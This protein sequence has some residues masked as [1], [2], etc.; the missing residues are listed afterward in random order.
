MRRIIMCILI[1][2]V[3]IFVSYILY[4][5]IENYL[6][7]QNIV[8]ILQCTS[9]DYDNNYNDVFYIDGN[10]NLHEVDF[11]NTSEVNEYLDNEKLYSKLSEVESDNSESFISADNIK[12][13]YSD[14]KK[15]DKHDSWGCRYRHYGTE[16][17]MRYELYGVL[18][19]KNGSSELINLSLDESETGYISNNEYGK[20][21]AKE[22]Q[23]TFLEED[24]SNQNAKRVAQKM[25][26]R[27]SDEPVDEWE[28][29]MIGEYLITPRDNYNNKLICEAEQLLEE[30]YGQKFVVSYK[31]IFENHKVRLYDDAFWGES[32][33][34]Q[35]LTVYFKAYPDGEPENVFSFDIMDK[36]N[37]LVIINS[38]YDLY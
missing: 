20:K 12:I 13:L 31:V 27:W 23:K 7:N 34:P 5:D 4:T 19:N 26:K 17:G 32:D 25:Q 24:Y 30:K 1:F 22:I 29:V 28:Y 37:E 2:C 18:E 16:E 9:T 8:F 38:E 35:Y 36:G 10:G 33:A 14:L 3:L 11:S 6:N 15:A 21:I